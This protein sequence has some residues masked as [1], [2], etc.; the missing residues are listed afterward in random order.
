MKKYI[1]RNFF[2]YISKNK[3]TKNSWDEKNTNYYYTNILLSRDKRE[4]SF[5][6]LFFILKESGKN[7]LVSN[8]LIF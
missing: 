1:V 2:F 4:L 8:F 6:F 7:E 3:Y 5:S